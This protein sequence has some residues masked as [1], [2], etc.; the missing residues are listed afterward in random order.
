MTLTADRPGT[1]SASL[2]LQLARW[3]EQR[4]HDSMAAH[5]SL[6][7]LHAIDVL[8]PDALADGAAAAARAYF[9]AEAPSLD[10][11]A[12][13]PGVAA[14]RASDALAFVSTRWM[15][16]TGSGAPR[17]GDFPRRRR[18]RVVRVVTDDGA[19]VVARFDDA[20]DV[21]VIAAAA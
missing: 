20:P 12:D 3:F 18:A 21:V 11:L 9:V 17:P 5:S 16:P 6:M 10:A 14:A 15:A 8:D 2:A 19:A 7:R 13:R 4:L 1:P